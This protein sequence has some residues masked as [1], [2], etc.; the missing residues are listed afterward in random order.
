MAVL[1]IYLLVEN[2][3][4]RFI[5]FLNYSDEVVTLYLLI[6]TLF[7]RRR[8]SVNSNGIKIFAF[9]LATIGIGIV[10]NLLFEYQKNPVAV[11][12]DIL[13]VSK[14]F[15]VYICSAYF[16][17]GIR[18]RQFKQ[19]CAFSKVYLLILAVCGCLSQFVDMGM[20]LDVRFGIKS[21]LFLYSHPTF[22][23]SATI[24]M[25]TVLYADGSRKN[26]WYIL[27]GIGVMAL[28]MRSKSI[29]YIVCILFFDLFLN[30]R[31][32]HEGVK[33]FIRKNK[34]KIGISVATGVL[35]AFILLRNKVLTYLRWGIKA[36]RPA[37]YIIAFRIIRDCFP[38]GSGFGTFA[39]YL[40][41]K[42][43]SP[44]YRIYGIAHVS[45]LDAA[46]G[47][48]YVADTYWPYILAQFGVTGTVVYLLA[49][50]YTIRNTLY[51][52]SGSMDA[53]VA[54]I[55]L[56]VYMI[57]ACFVEAMLTNANIIIIALC[58]GYYLSKRQLSSGK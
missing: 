49:I 48:E 45:G 12:K 13:A 57:A 47:F 46:S 54:T 33:E 36:A 39:S 31:D 22:L 40:S 32:I 18:E 27:L 7:T 10:G 55:S 29:V 38:I 2:I 37:L 53:F 9:W 6:R 17:R 30:K 24:I 28:T 42:Y 52:V 58:M 3:L 43:S 14:F 50:Y 11:I 8:F 4:E 44:I 23:A 41:T 15:I 21:F 35:L 51:K 25:V 34:I 19:I 16:Y 56:L 5:P 1:Y 20:T 26:R